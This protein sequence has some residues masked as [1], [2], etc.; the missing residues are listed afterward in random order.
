MPTTT[1][2]Q[3]HLQGP[4]ILQ[5]CRTCRAGAIANS[6]RR[7]LGSRDLPA[8]AFVPSSS[9]PSTLA[10][11]GVRRGR[12]PG[13]SGVHRAVVNPRIRSRATDTHV[14]SLH[15][16]QPRTR[17][18]HQVEGGS[19]D[20][21]PL[22]P[23]RLAAHP[24]LCPLDY[25]RGRQVDT[26]STSTHGPGLLSDR[27]LEHRHGMKVLWN[28]SGALRLGTSPGSCALPDLKRHRPASAPAHPPH[29]SRTRVHHTSHALQCHSE[30]R[31]ERVSMDPW[32]ARYRPSLGSR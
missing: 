32:E 5:S 27:C 8:H 29:P 15:R 4:C 21:L 20:L 25:A 3:S 28:P 7:R 22:Y 23:S 19:A 31:C 12:R 24:V 13:V 30:A 14:P 10:A 18:C 1:A 16:A 6:G 9:R 26:H 2:Y 17:H 11:H